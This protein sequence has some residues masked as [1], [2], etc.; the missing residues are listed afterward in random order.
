MSAG[1]NWKLQGCD[2][3]RGATGKCR[4]AMSAGVNWK[5]QGWDEIYTSWLSP[6]GRKYKLTLTVI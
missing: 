1:V 4:A 3:C 6:V 2:E 5:M